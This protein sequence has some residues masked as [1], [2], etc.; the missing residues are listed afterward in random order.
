M[1]LTPT[2]KFVLLGIAVASLSACSTTK[3]A[4]MNTAPSTPSSGQVQ[5]TPTMD[6]QYGFMTDSTLTNAQLLA[7][8]TYYFQFNSTDLLG[9]NKQAVDA[10]GTY[11]STQST[12]RVLL[13][14]NTDIQGSFEYN[15]GLG[16]RR[17][18]AVQQEL[19]AQGTSK[20]QLELVSFGPECPSN[21]AHTQ[22]AYQQNRRVQLIYCQ[23]ESCQAAY[24]QTNCGKILKG[25]VN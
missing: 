17:A 15:I 6:N 23:G 18:M 24:Q 7:I 8:R 4:P 1:K 2:S 11:L 16:Y 12:Q 9:L 22:D 19:M 10:Q 14:G 21:P 5:T 25:N 20:T 13:A 3:H